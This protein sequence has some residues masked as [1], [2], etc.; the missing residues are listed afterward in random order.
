[1]GQGGGRC[2]QIN[3]AAILSSLLNSLADD[4]LTW[5]IELKGSR[6]KTILFGTIDPNVGGWGRVVPNF[7]SVDS[8]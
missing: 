7:F 8:R 2:S 4:C 3:S 1:M 5:H 6:K